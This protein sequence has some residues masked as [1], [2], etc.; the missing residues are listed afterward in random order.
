L[1]VAVVLGL[2]RLFRLDRLGRVV[3]AMVH[4]WWL[5]KSLLGKYLETNL[6]H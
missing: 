5:F 6:H 4:S 3:V 1:V 2:C